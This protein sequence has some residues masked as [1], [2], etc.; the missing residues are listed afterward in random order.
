MEDTC[1]QCTTD[2]KSGHGGFYHIDIWIGSSTKNGN[3][4]EETC[5]DKLTPKERHTII[6][7]PST[8]LPVDGKS[9]DMLLAPFRVSEVEAEFLFATKLYDVKTE[10]CRTSHV[11]NTFKVKDYCSS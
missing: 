7:N 11:Y 4:N 2:W 6:R 8:G 1:D 3:N 10:G 5:E 9:L